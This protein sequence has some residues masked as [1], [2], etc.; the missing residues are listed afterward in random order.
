MRKDN[1][2]IEMLMMIVMIITIM[3]TIPMMTSVCNTLALPGCHN[4]FF[5][6]CSHITSNTTTAIP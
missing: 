4:I 3:I 5:N 2:V 6:S 1:Y